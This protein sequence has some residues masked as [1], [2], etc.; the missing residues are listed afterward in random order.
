M[1]MQDKKPGVEVSRQVIGGWLFAISFSFFFS[2]VK[3]G[4]ILIPWI[5]LFQLAH[6]CLGLIRHCLDSE[7]KVN[8]KGKWVCVGLEV[9][10]GSWLICVS[11]KEIAFWGERVPCTGKKIFVFL[12]SS[13]FHLSLVS[14][15]CMELEQSNR[16]S[17]YAEIQ[18]GHRWLVAR[19]DKEIL[20]SNCHT[21]LPHP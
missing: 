16:V 11:W 21:I 13:T 12:L 5:L 9:I 10:S 17:W 14:P 4:L 8:F 6:P 3:L 2:S 18:P 20:G 15:E 7:Q 19:L 1:R